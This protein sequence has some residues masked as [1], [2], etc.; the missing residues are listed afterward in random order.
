MGNSTGK[1]IENTFCHKNLADIL[2]N[3]CFSFVEPSHEIEINYSIK[4]VS[5]LL[6]PPPQ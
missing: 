6:S 5:L 3:K 2:K 1:L 4:K